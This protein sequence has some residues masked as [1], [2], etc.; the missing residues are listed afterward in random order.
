MKADYKRRDIPMEIL[1]R[2]VMKMSERVGNVYEMT[3]LLG[4]R[5]NQITMEEKRDIYSKLKEFNTESD[6]LEEVFENEEQIEISKYFEKL[7]KPTMVAIQEYIEGKL[8]ERNPE[9]E[10]RE[11]ME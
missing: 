8:Y 9:K 2:D 4:I 11:S 5:A 1:T 10:R 3:R 7:P 6:S